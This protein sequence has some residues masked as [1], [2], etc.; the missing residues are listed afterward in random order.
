MFNKITYLMLSVPEKILK[1]KKAKMTKNQKKKKQKREKRKKIK[2]K[3]Q[4]LT[5]EQRT[6]NMTNQD[7][8]NNVKFH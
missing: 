5:R 2:K 8:E 1:I 7:K 3:P 6:P 4:M